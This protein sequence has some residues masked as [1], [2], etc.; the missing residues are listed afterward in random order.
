MK[1]ENKLKEKLLNKKKVLGCW[2]SL[3]NEI[4]S[5][6][7]ALVG[8]DF[9]LIDHEH[10]YGDVKGITRQV[11]SLKE[12]E[13][14]PLVRMPK[15]DEVYVKKTLDTG[16]NSLMFPLVNNKKEAENI[17]EEPYELSDGHVVIPNKI[18]TGI[19]FNK[20][21]IKKYEYKY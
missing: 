12:T 4:T 5:E 1:L 8:F 14:S 6:L 7:L 21:T 13:C 19:D 18:G 10:G 3:D 15:D 16:V 9:L 17:V 2:T 11:Q 20:D